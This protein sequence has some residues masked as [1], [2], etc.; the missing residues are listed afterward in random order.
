LQVVRATKLLK[1]LSLYLPFYISLHFVIVFYFFSL[2][3]AVYMCVLCQATKDIHI[4]CG[5][6]TT[7]TR[8]I[9][10][11]AT[12]R[13]KYLTVAAKYLKNE[14][15]AR[16]SQKFEKNE[17]KLV[18]SRKRYSSKSKIKYF[19]ISTTYFAS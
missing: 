2:V 7:A 8:T 19:T 16:V 4:T 5:K 12:T 18:Q 9:R 13:P 6:A 3:L 11:T 10:T 15:N 1:L 14:T 17:E